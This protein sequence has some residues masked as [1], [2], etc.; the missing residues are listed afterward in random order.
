MIYEKKDVNN[1][2]WISQTNE[3]G[4][5][6]IPSK[7]QVW[8]RNIGFW[9]SEFRFIIKFVIIFQALEN[10]MKVY[11]W[12]PYWIHHLEIWLENRLQWSRNSPNNS[13]QANRSKE[14]KKLFNFKNV[15]AK[16]DPPFFIFIV[17]N[18]KSITAKKS[19]I[20]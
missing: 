13:F 20:Y 18:L 3:Y 5:M 1:A 4:I 9:I 19:R 2:L 7:H 8:D 11:I 6:G 16:L 15:T 17:S 14:I 12:P 10:E